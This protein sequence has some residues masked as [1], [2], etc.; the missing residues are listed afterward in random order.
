MPNL[1]SLILGVVMA[2]LVAMATLIPASAAL[3]Q[4]LDPCP[5]DESIEADDPACVPPCEELPTGYDPATDAYELRESF[6]WSG[7]ESCVVYAHDPE[8]LAAVV[9]LRRL[10]VLGAVLVIFLLSGIFA[11][12]WFR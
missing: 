2:A 7:K 6:D 3:A 9:D 4:V 5:Y 10:V 1:R 11:I 12:G 8:L